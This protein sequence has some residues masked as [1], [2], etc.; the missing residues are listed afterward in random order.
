MFNL[1]KSG[2]PLLPSLELLAEQNIIS[3][4]FYQKLTSALQAGHPLSVAL[5]QQ[6]FPELY[7]SFIRAAEERGDYAFGFKQCEQY[8][9]MRANL[10]HQLLQASAYPLLML[11]L[12][13]IIFTFM[14]T[15]VLPRFSELYQMMGLE[16]PWMTTSLFYFFQGLRIFLFLLAGSLCVLFVMAKVVQRQPKERRA[17]YARRMYGLPGIKHISQFWMTHYL[18]IQLGS[19]LQAGVPLLQALHLIEEMTPWS[20]LSLRIGEIKTKITQGMPLHQSLEN[21]HFTLFLPSLTQMVAIGEK[22][23]RLDEM[24]LSLAEWTQQW[25]KK[26][27]DR[28]LRSLGP[29][30]ILGV[31]AIVALTVLAMFL[32]MLQLIKAM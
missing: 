28:L 5:K 32:P 2:L 29:V 1:C 10:A 13:T 24:L 17:I 21:P 14:I 25:M 27:T 19:L 18:S 3:V 15:V 4:S 9:T 22:T 12:V 7:V 11:G 26:K 16:L 20:Y 30:L 6:N 31:G 8:D 23:G